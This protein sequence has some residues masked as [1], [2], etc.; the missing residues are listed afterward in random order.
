MAAAVFLS[1]CSWKMLKQPLS[2]LCWLLRSLPSLQQRNLLYLASLSQWKL[3]TS[4]CT[5]S[6]LSSRH[7]SISQSHFQPKTA[8][9]CD[10]LIWHM[11]YTKYTLG[12]GAASRPWW[13]ERERNQM[14][15]QGE[16]GSFRA[17]KHEDNGESCFKQNLRQ[18][19]PVW[20]VWVSHGWGKA[21]EEWRFGARLQAAQDGLFVEMV[22]L[23]KT[24]CTMR[25]SPAGVGQAGF[26]W[27]QP[28]DHFAAG[29]QWVTKPLA[30][31]LSYFTSCPKFLCPS[32]FLNHFYYPL[33]WLCQAAAVGSAVGQD[34]VSLTSNSKNCFC[35]CFL[36]SGEQ[37]WASVDW[38]KAE[39]KRD[40]IATC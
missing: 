35:A 32:F 1:L 29:L 37:L 38:V 3:C 22:S 18:V 16:Q 31:L 21:K 19:Y 13:R 12:S 25:A 20:E 2:H 5:G 33:H 11:T 36:C 4:T 26:V 24:L 9:N 10:F 40:R 15:K 27:S 28:S 8:I 7:E 30:A 17:R 23:C 34:L 39:R 6:Q 14:S